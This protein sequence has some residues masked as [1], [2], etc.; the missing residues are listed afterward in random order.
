MAQTGSVK[1]AERISYILADANDW[2]GANG[3]SATID[4][5]FDLSGLAAGAYRQSAKLDLGAL[6]DKDLLIRIMV[7]MQ[8]DPAAGELLSLS[9]DWT[10]DATAGT[11]NAA[12]LTGVDGAYTGFGGVSAEDAVDHLLEYLAPFTLLAIDDADNAPQQKLLATIR[13]KS[14][15][16]IFV[17]GNLCDVADIYSTA[18]NTAIKITSIETQQHDV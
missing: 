2:S 9:A 6:W 5:Q 1:I 3:W 15:Y 13:P 7:E 12:G 4:A 17:L 14:R 16:P 10:Q 11:G 18:D 8:V